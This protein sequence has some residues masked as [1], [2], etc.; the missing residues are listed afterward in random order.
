V[1]HNEEARAFLKRLAGLFDQCSVGLSF[2]QSADGVGCIAAQLRA[3]LVRDPLA[4]LL[5]QE[6]PVAFEEADDRAVEFLQYFA[7]NHCA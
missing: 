2:A 4:Y 1:Q 5:L 3:S 6:D 7:R